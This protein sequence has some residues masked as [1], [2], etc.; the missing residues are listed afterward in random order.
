MSKTVLSAFFAIV[1]I[2]S[3]NGVNSKFS[4][5]VEYSQSSFV[6]KS[7][8]MKE[9]LR[10][11][12]A[13]SPIFF[14]TAGGRNFLKESPAVSGRGGNLT[15]VWSINGRNIAVEFVRKQNEYQISFKA[16]P[17][18]DIIRWGFSISASG[19]EYFTGLMERTVDGEQALS[20]RA[21]V[22][23]TMDLRGQVVE[24]LVKP[25]LGLYCPFYISSN[26]YSLF[27]QGTWPGEYDFC[28][29]DANC[30]R[31]SFEGSSLTVVLN[32]G[33]PAELIKRHCIRTGPSIVPPRWVFKPWRWRDEHTQSDK[34]Y[35][36][37]KV[38][39][40]YNSELVEDILMMQGYDIPCGVYLIDRPW[41]VGDLGYCD[42]DWDPNRFPNA[43]EMIGWLK[44]NDIKTVLWISPWVMGNMYVEA[45]NKKYNIDGQ[46]RQRKQ[47]AKI[48][49]T[50]PR[51]VKWWQNTGLAKVLKQGVKGFKLDRSEELTPY[52]YTHRA[53][54]GR[55]SRE[56]HNDY[57]VMYAK[58]VNQIC[59]KFYG[60]DFVILPRA[61]YAGSGKYAAF[62]GGDIGNGTNPTAPEAL[63]CAIIAFQKASV[64]GFGLWGSDT[65]GY[66]KLIDH[67]VAARW[68]GFS[69]FTPIMEVG[70]TENKGFWGLKE[71]PD[72]DGQLIAIW[73]LY[74]K[75]HDRLADY[76]F[77]CAIEA[78]KS[79]M[80][81]G[82]PL[83][84]V[85]PEKK[86][87]RQDWQTYMYGDDIL[88][89][90]VW[91]KGQ[92]RQKLYLPDGE[93]WVDAWDKS[94]VY[95]GG[96]SITVD[97]PVHKIPI[98]I[99]QGAKIDLG[100]L[101][102][103]YEESLKITSQKPDLD[104]LQKT[105]FGRKKP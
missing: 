51:A 33:S 70:P 4:A 26:N 25:T 71:Q 34:Y 19:D 89:S 81:I 43:V 90:A 68:L 50:N 99:R 104:K 73:R 74:A 82:R 22:K 48:D 55:L 96:Q 35:D 7:P 17:C 29:A 86:E 60:D 65:C 41:A 62:W 76:T 32:T 30:V 101:N 66:T 56:Y 37:S 80:P 102:M 84:M 85:C 98:F 87:A 45:I 97:T 13:S 49:F 40:P 61:G 36:G 28:K 69:C 6:L 18:D 20:W 83:F 100:N 52:D 9:P 10:L 44:K 75:I 42:F 39:A 59:R 1:S 16:S 11:G 38:A 31:I 5:G 3:A 24:M 14:E 15:A 77:S 53:Y 57:P 23:E 91:Q 67:E 79:G 12:S 105:A 64:M 78:A 46:L 58:S 63:R 93:M 27:A 72:Y 92:R 2:C 8:N 47:L 54:D 21:D 88:V 95:Q 103:L 94:R